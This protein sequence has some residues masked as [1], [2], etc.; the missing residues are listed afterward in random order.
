MQNLGDFTFPNAAEMG[1]T[2]N[3]PIKQVNQNYVVYQEGIYVGYKYY[4][5]RYEDTVLGQGNT[6]GYDYGIGAVLK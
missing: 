5:T 3:D 2:Q 4:E 1:L 6:A